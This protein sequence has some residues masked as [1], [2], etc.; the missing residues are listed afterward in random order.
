M[1][2]PRFHVLIILL[3]GL[4]LL[5]HGKPQADTP[6]TISP[7]VFTGIV[8]GEEDW[9]QR[10]LLRW[11]AVDEIVDPQ[12]TVLFR[13]GQDGVRHK[14]SVVKS[15]RN[16]ALIA[17]IFYR[18]GEDAI[19]LDAR[20]ILEDI[21]GTAGSS[22][23]EFAQR[24][25]DL[26]EGQD[27]S[28]YAQLRRK[29]LEQI[30]YGFALVEGHGYLDFVDP[31]DGPFLYELWEGNAS[32]NAV[33]ALGKVTI[34][35]SQPDVLAP[36]QELKE[37]SLISRDQVSP[38]VNNNQRIYLDWAAPLSVDERPLTFGYNVYR[39]NRALQ[40]GEFFED[41]QNEVERINDNPIL[42]PSPMPDTPPDQS[43]VYVD[44]GEWSDTA[45]DA[46][47]LPVGHVY[48][49]WVV[50][51][52]LLGQEGYPSDP[53]QA[54]VRD[55]VPPAVPRGLNVFPEQLEDG[56]P[57]LRARWPHQGGETVLYRLYR[58]QD[59]GHTGKN[60]PFPDINGLTEGL[61]AEVPSPEGDPTPT[62]AMHD[63][64]EVSSAD[65][66]RG[67]WYCL[68][69]VD[70]SGNE[71]PLSPPTYAAIDDVVGPSPGRASLICTSLTSISV[72]GTREAEST[73]REEI[74]RPAFL[75]VKEDP[76]FDRVHI[77][78]VYPGLPGIADEVVPLGPVVFGNV[79]T[80]VS[81]DVIEDVVDQNDIPT[82]RFKVFTIDGRTESVDVAPPPDWMPGSTREVYTIT[83]TARGSEQ[84]CDQAPLVP[85]KI[86]TAIPGG[87]IPPFKLT[88]PCSGDVESLR[89]YRSVDGGSTYQLVN[90]T[91][92]DGATLDLVDPYH[93]EGL[94][95]VKYSVVAMDKHGNPGPP[96]YLP[97]RILFLGDIP[98]P[99]LKSVAASG[100]P[101][102]PK[103]SLKWTGPKSGILF[104][105]VHFLSSP[106]G[107]PDPDKAVE[108]AVSDLTY[109]E[110]LRE[111]SALV[112]SIDRDGTAISTSEDYYVLVEAVTM[113]GTSRFATKSLPLNWG[114]SNAFQSPEFTGL[115][116]A[117]RPMPPV[118][119]RG[120]YNK[121]YF[122]S[123]HGGA[124]L[125]LYSIPSQEAGV[126]G[127]YYPEPPVMV[128]RKRTDK[129]NTP[130]V[131]VSPFITEVNYVAD[132]L[133]DAFF[134]IESVTQGLNGVYFIDNSGLVQG[135]TYDY[136][137][138]GFDPD[139][140]EITSLVGPI[141]GIAVIP[142]R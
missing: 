92:C 119:A 109:N 41:V 14:I 141:E 142:G 130:F 139:N 88:F 120:S 135:A 36:P 81:G 124:M 71:S 16:G 100:L 69:A 98:T 67:Y 72:Q 11:Y 126:G 48:T 66:A 104:Y 137:F 18:P 13:T 140:N 85:G 19:L 127:G 63:D 133:D 44:E 101:G 54:V 114:A 37:V 49:Y 106:D 107:L 51:R 96:F 20:H 28:D 61:I 58:F 4:F 59:Y 70:D 2:L 15:T 27:A 95:D 73:G 86:I 21:Y 118:M 52:D 5:G 8:G 74:W 125:V 94:A 93:P 112:D 50:A 91:P 102:N 77:S 99:V 116:W 56:T 23:E 42:A 62:H 121:A 9:G 43:Y 1:R 90:E 97:A 113:A 79:G 33:N 75:L 22:K 128:W 40:P 31:L 89:L 78:R 131:A 132:L 53:L 17:S 129:P 68:S 39:L 10:V 110:S 3:A 57:Y 46:D 103:A 26:L 105:R 38:S 34:D 7:L 30:N 60:T 87:D 136:Y 80:Y 24:V 122:T 83:M 117:P 76:I 45:D 32:G 123:E 64:K 138:M 35:A 55:T 84:I 108:L 12:T 82:Y 6:P 115:R 111:Y 25:I 29:F 134:T 47:L 65:F